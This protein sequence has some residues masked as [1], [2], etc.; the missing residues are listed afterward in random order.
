MVRVSL[1]PLLIGLLLLLHSSIGLALELTLDEKRATSLAQ[2]YFPQQL[3]VGEHSFD[4]RNP[5]VFV[6]DDRRVGIRT[7]FTAQLVS[8]NDAAQSSKP[9]GVVRGAMLISALPM[10][11]RGHA[12]LILNAVSLD[13][14]VLFDGAE[15]NGELHR[16][17]E[18]Q[19]QQ[20]LD[21]VERIELPDT[22]ELALLTRNLERFEVVGD[23]LRLVYSG[24]LF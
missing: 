16:F 12:L 8:D 3:V 17:L 19:L 24:P 4:A 11:L 6:M 18:K 5:R 21:R 2:W 13:S 23:T 9:Q 14:L 1:M 20:E 7:E 10:Y 22:G 15:N